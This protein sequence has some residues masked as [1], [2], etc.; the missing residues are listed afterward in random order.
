M[1]NVA[2]SG[3]EVVTVAL[4]GVIVVAVIGGIGYY[5]LASS[6]NTGVGFSRSSL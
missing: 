6:V 3:P 2:K 4:V 5:E 1:I